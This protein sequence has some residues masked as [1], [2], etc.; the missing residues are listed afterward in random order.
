MDFFWVNE[1]EKTNFGNETKRQKIKESLQSQHGDDISPIMS[2]F[3]VISNYKPKD[4]VRC[5]ITHKVKS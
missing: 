3:V 2:T 4:S 5:E 1:K